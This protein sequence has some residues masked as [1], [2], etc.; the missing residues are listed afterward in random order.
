MRA[1]FVLLMMSMCIPPVQAMQQSFS[2]VRRS[3]RAAGDP[4][5]RRH[6]IDTFIEGIRATGAPLIENDSTVVFLYRGETDS[7]GLVGDMTDWTDPIPLIRI[8]NTDLWYYRATF[9]PDAR[10][11]YGFQL[12]DAVMPVP[13][14]LNP[15]R[16]LDGWEEVFADWGGH[17]ELAMPQYAHRPV[18]AAIRD[19]T[20]GGYE[21][22]TR[23]EVP[24]GALGYPHDIYIYLPS[25]YGRTQRRYPVVYLQDGQDYIEYAHTPAVLNA[26]IHAGQIEPVIAVFVAPP[27]RHQPAMPNRAT[28]YGLNDDYIRFFSQEL[29]P[30]VEARYRTQ[31]DSAARL[32]VGSS[33]GGLIS[34][35]IAFRHPDVLGLVYGQSGYYSFQDDL[36]IR[37]I[38]EAPQKAIQLYIDVGTYERRIGANFLPSDEN[39]FLKANRRLRE[40][41][42]DKGYNFIYHE[43]P[44]GHT[45]GNWR[46]HLID[47]LLYFFGATPSDSSFI[48]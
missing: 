12:P 42:K 27:N 41:L 3:I 8:E 16:V 17:S 10:L 1:F 47:A 13:D 6:V 4:A 40:V 21:R 22:V 11:Q 9:E 43:Y 34:V 45:W 25:G 20:E 29:V 2:D 33:Y 36:L 15:Y 30:F 46:A 28:E 35:A 19:G 32:V 48:E 31:Q 44:E 23:H 39:N 7:V 5:E 24:A 18:F 26:L 37:Q 14:P 38:A